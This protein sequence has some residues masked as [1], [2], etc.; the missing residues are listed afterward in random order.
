MR[1]ATIPE[2]KQK[3]DTQRPFFKWLGVGILIFGLVWSLLLAHCMHQS[4]VF[5]VEMWLLVLPVIYLLTNFPVFLAE[6]VVGMHRPL[7]AAPAFAVCLIPRQ[8]WAS[9][10]P[11]V[12]TSPPRHRLASCEA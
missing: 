8:F 5:A 10:V 12:P 9:F 2:I 1:F 11:S 7:I 6:A 4:V 3:L